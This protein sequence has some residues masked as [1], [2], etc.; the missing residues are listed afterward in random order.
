MVRGHDTWSADL[1]Q[2]DVQA[3]LTRQR[4]EQAAWHAYN[5]LERATNAVREALA[6]PDVGAEWK[7]QLRA[8]CRRVGALA[9]EE[10]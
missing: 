2:F 3:G 5:G 10:V 1:G 8:V 6:D 7:G 9:E 4:A